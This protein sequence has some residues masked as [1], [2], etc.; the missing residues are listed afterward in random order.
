MNKLLRL[1]AIKS[2]NVIQLTLLAASYAVTRYLPR[3]S[4][5]WVVGPDEVAGVLRGISQ[6]LPDNYSVNLSLPG[7]RPHQYSYSINSGPLVLA[8]RLIIGPILLGSLMNQSDQFFYIWN[9]GFLFNRSREFWFLKRKNKRI[10]LMFCGDDIRS[11]QLHSDFCQ[12]LGRD[13]FVNYDF[14]L[15]PPGGIKEYERLQKMTASDAEK[16]ADIVFNAPNC[17]TSYLSSDSSK[18]IMAHGFIA[19]SVDDFCYDDSKFDD[20]KIK[21][22]HAPSSMAVKGT[23][24]VRDAIA[25]LSSERNDFDYIELQGVPHDEVIK[26]LHGAHVCLNQFLSFG[27]GVL[28]IEAMASRCATLMSADPELEPSIPRSPQGE[29][30]WVITNTSQI[31]E[32]LKMLLDNR[33]MLKNI[34]DNGFNYAL[35]HYET[36]KANQRLR[37]SLT[38][39]G[40]AVAK[41]E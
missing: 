20:A 8:R 30:P 2:L 31:Y 13:S 1:L 7:L 15:N 35:Q 22:V 19:I 5:S 36:T 33:K 16:F 3:K 39:H 27:T 37:D 41:S 38:S 32:N 29:N 12:S 18:I 34:S 4:Y 10:A 28:G 26:T 17:Q 6:A 9:R 14:Y 25:Q 11:P 40:F 24:Y 21:V 23:S